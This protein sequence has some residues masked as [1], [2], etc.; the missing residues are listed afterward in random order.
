MG[1]KPE[2]QNRWKFEETNTRYPKEIDARIKTVFLKFPFFKEA[3]HFLLSWLHVSL[4][5]LVF[6]CLPEEHF[7]LNVR[8]FFARHRVIWL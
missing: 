3:K 2:E 1:L 5:H 7:C 8:L 6:L 4:T